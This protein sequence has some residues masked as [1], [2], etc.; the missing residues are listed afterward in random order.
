MRTEHRQQTEFIREHPGFVRVI[1]GSF[2]FF[3]LCYLLAR[4]ALELETRNT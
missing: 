4:S 1:R 2:S 3:C